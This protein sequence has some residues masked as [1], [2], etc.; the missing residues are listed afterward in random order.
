MAR[1]LWW[2]V[3]LVAV[4]AAFPAQA[5]PSQVRVSC[6]GSAPLGGTA[7]CSQVFSVPHFDARDQIDTSTLVARFTPIVA[8][9]WRVEGTLSDAQGVAY[10]QWYCDVGRSVM[11][12]TTSFYLARTCEETRRTISGL[13]GAPFY[14]ADVRQLHRLTITARAASCLPTSVLGCRF[15]G[16]ATFLIAG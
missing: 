15:E 13:P 12:G 5:E 2:F 4:L 1:R 16:A 8:N 6:S 7:T 3:A 10:F 9:G 11:L 14:V